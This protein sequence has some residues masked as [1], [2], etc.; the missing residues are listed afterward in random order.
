[1]QLHA[2]LPKRCINIIMHVAHQWKKNYKH[3]LVNAF[4]NQQRAIIG[5]HTYFYLFIYFCFCFTL[6]RSCLHSRDFLSITCSLWGSHN[7]SKHTYFPSNTASYNCVD[8]TFSLN[9][10]EEYGGSFS[11]SHKN[12]ANDPMVWFKSAGYKSRA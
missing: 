11:I 6:W 2:P 3:L 4:C 8:P 7:E 5:K 12:R 1:M 10:I 9:D